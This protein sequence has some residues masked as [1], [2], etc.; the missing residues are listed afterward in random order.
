MLG[1]RWII[2]HFGP[3]KQADGTSIWFIVECRSS[4]QR[5][6]H[7][8]ALAAVP[9]PRCYWGIICEEVCKGTRMSTIRSAEVNYGRARGT[10][11]AG[12]STAVLLK[13]WVS[14]GEIVEG[15]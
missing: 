6:M 1:R 2:V 10:T 9:W 7:I 13:Y 12:D 4:A 5:A 11:T 8:A 15:R 14:A 3:P